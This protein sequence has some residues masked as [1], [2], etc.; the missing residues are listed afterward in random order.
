MLRYTNQR[1]EYD[2]H[3][4][5]M[6]QPHHWAIRMIFVF[7]HGFF[8]T[9]VTLQ[10]PYVAMNFT[11]SWNIWFVRMDDT[12]RSIPNC[13]GYY[14]MNNSVSIISPFAFKDWIIAEI[15]VWTCKLTNDR[16]LKV[17]R[18]LSW[19]ST[20]LITNGTQRYKMLEVHLENLYTY[21]IYT[22]NT[23][24]DYTLQYN[25]NQYCI[26]LYNTIEFYTILYIP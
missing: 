7:I 6:D 12:Q 23:I 17:E 14:P 10:L 16:E 20:D 8:G 11:H 18:P 13:Y 24:Q 9:R 19:P 4:L 22:I 21:Y 5:K 15:C 25:T 3:T 26:V 2:M 1:C